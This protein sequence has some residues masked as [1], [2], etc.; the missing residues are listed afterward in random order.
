[1][2]TLRVGAVVVVAAVVVAAWMLTRSPAPIYRTTV[3]R[4]GTVDATLDSVGTVAPVNQA[5]LAFATSGTIGSVDVSVGS[6]VTAGQTV[7][8]LDPT[9][10]NASVVSAQAMLAAAQATLAAAEASQS[11]PA[12][13]P[14]AAAAPTTTTPASSRSGQSSPDAQ[15]IA[16]LQATLVTDQAQEDADASSAS[17]SLAAATSLCEAAPSGGSTASA[18]S[19]GAAGSTG[20]NGAAGSGPTSPPTS[21]GTGGAITC[22]QAL[23]QAS[24][25][26]D[27]VSADI[28]Q[29]TH[30]E[31]A[32]NAALEPAPGGAASN[33]PQAP[34]VA[35][36]TAFVSSS[37]NAV[38]T[39]VA[40]VGTPPSGSTSSGSASGGGGSRSAATPATA[41]QLAVDQAAVD[42]A[43]AKLTDAQQALDDVNLVSTISGT[44]A[45]ISIAVG[46]PITAASGSA[47]PEIVV[48]GPGSS[49]QVVTQV[50]VADIGEVAVGQSATV[51]PDATN[52]VLEGT[53]TSIGLLPVSGTNGTTY[54]VTISLTS[55]NL[56]PFSGA[57]AS[58]TIVVARSEDVTAVP[59]S[60]VR[61]TGSIHLVTVV[62]GG[63]T[64]TARVA[65]GTVGDVLTQVTS[66]LKP[67]DVVALADLG[68]PL[69]TTSTAVGGRFG[70]LGG[71]GLGGGGLA[72]SA[73]AGGSGGVGFVGGAG[74]P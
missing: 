51:T 41:Q 47:D 62:D 39:D 63:T 74:G 61:T 24:A 15:Q 72:R 48:I 32:L 10:L 3:V 16:K 17:Q 31:S 20:S 54:P 7:A 40:T 56:G 2:A 23:A 36:I 34:P 28:K 6:T 4:A 59:T 45:S 46:D 30:D 18:G 58:A 70:G 13:S 37:Q 11:A 12:S 22:A 29:V 44:V 49:Y 33:A 53:V 66:G 68:Q 9:Q 60:A 71:G 35:T 26:Q 73:A 57:D 14:S 65:L 43:Q 64:R 5:G 50:P 52:S 55:G 69:P 67:G 1:M 19:N 38:A 27:K 8:S 42:T 25:A 21:D